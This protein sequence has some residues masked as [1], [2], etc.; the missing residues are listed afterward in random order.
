MSVTELRPFKEAEDKISWI[1]TE[2]E[3]LEA[4]L[5][6]EKRNELNAVTKSDVAA[7]KKAIKGLEIELKVQAQSLKIAKSN[8]TDMQL[9]IEA[10]QSTTNNEIQKELDE[11]SIITALKDMNAN[12]IVNGNEW[13]CIYGNGV[14]FQPL[15]K[16]LS[17]EE[18]I[19]HVFL[20]SDHWVDKFKLK[21]IAKGAN[22]MYRDVE[23]T[24]QGT[25]KSTLNQLNELREFWLKPDFSGESHVAF[26]ILT[27]NL[28]GHKDEYKDQIEK[29][30]AY[31]Y[32]RP[33]DIFAPNI[34]SSAKGGVGRDTFF[35]MLEIIFTEE[36]CGEAKKETVQGT[37]N[38]ELNGKIWVKVSEQNNRVMNIEELKNLTG[39]HN[40]RLR[41]MGQNA[42]QVPRTFRFF[43][44]SNNYEGTAKLTGGG[45]GTED[46]RWEPIFSNTSLVKALTDEIAIKDGVEPDKER[47]VSILEQWQQEVY[48]DEKEIAKWLGHIITKHGYKD[49]YE[50][51]TKSIS[52]LTALHGEYYTEMLDRQKRVFDT[53]METVVVLSENSNCYVMTKMH[54]IFSLL[55]LGNKI[56]DK[57]QFAKMF[58]QWLTLKTN[59]TWEIKLSP[60]YGNEDDLA[61]HRKK[62]TIVKLAGTTADED[63]EQPKL[64]FEV[65]DFLHEGMV[66]EK[67]KE[68][69]ER[70]HV[71]NI[72]EEFY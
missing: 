41:E 71:N 50:G 18:M 19:D 57:G 67:N 52:K 2:I 35:R 6:T 22:R 47:V 66:D 5:I 23:R 60:Y 44:M 3:T 49:Y 33:E 15:V 7:A 32:V 17:H 40:F 59:Q 27:H 25:K 36:C 70:P 10:N 4:K 28:V 39:G 63:D 1:E 37:H 12:F 11:L 24:F 72:K 14:R 64:V 68:L 58:A 34:D 29:Y 31:S 54:K 20:V 21:Q 53:F 13:H 65:F 16:I 30:I 61:I 9:K 69:G 56:P 26:D 55:A 62:A 43:M 38:G 42:R 8:L 45:G 46:R 51:K 48:Q